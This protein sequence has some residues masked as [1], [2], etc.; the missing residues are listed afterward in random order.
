MSEPVVL[1]AEAEADLDEAVQWYE[2]R[3][4]RLGAQLVARVRDTLSRIGFNP[5]LYPEVYNGIRWAPVRRFPYG[6]F[7]RRHRGRVEVIAV[8]H[9][10]RNPSVWQSRV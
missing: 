10:R 8:F 4:T 9:D 7:Y 6:V 5:D 2:Q 3:S 1:T